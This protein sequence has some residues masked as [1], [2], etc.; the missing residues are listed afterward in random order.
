[1]GLASTGLGES[2]RHP[3][4]RPD[5]P[6]VR[7]LRRWGRGGGGKL[8][9]VQGGVCI[10]LLLYSLFSRNKRVNVAVFYT[11]FNRQILHSLVPTHGGASPS[12]RVFPRKVGRSP[13][14]VR[15]S[16]TP[17]GRD[18]VRTV[19]PDRGYPT[20]RPSGTNWR[21]NLRPTPNRLPLH[22]GWSSTTCVENLQSTGPTPH[23]WCPEPRV[24]TVSGPGDS[25]GLRKKRKNPGQN[26]RD[27]PHPT[28]V[29]IDYQTGYENPVVTG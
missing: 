4:P 12:R 5:P 28:S 3:G 8:P 22:Y 14:P 11:L 9:L 29:T 1:M 23:P 24:C 17:P 20:S 27:C 2:P 16:A 15:P 26:G 18:G 21:P 13:P 6:V 19:I 25:L 10:N 7:T